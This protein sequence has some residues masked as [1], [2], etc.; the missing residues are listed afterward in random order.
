VLPG[1]EHYRGGVIAY[2]LGNFVFT[3]DEQT[4]AMLRMTLRRGAAARHAVPLQSARVIPCRIINCRPQVIRDARQR[5]RVLR[6]L[7]AR[8]FGVR[9]SDDGELRLR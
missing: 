4:T 1:F 7:Q 6:A 8:S 2:S 5:R 3:Q 9:I